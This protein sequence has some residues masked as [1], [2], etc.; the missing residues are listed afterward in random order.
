MGSPKLP[1]PNFS[2]PT[3]Y[4]PSNS[5]PTT[6]S[7]STSNLVNAQTNPENPAAGENKNTRPPA[8]EGG[9]RR[10]LTRA[11]SNL[12]LFSKT[13]ESNPPSPSLHPSEFGAS[14]TDPVKSTTTTGMSSDVPQN[15]GTRPSTLHRMKSLPQLQ[16][17]MPAVRQSSFSS[18]SPASGSPTLLGSTRLRANRDAAIANHEIFQEAVGLAVQEY[19]ASYPKISAAKAEELVWKH[20]GKTYPKMSESEIAAAISSDCETTIRVVTSP[21]LEQ[22][23]GKIS[24]E[25]EKR[26][27][28]IKGEVKKEDFAEQWS[29]HVS[30]HAAALVVRHYPDMSSDVKEIIGK[31]LDGLKNVYAGTPGKVVSSDPS[32]I[33]TTLVQRFSKAK[34]MEVVQQFAK[35][36]EADKKKV[37]QDLID[38][39]ER[40]ISKEAHKL[41]GKIHPEISTLQSSPIIKKQLENHHL[42]DV[43]FI[44][45]YFKQACS[46]EFMGKLI[47][48]IFSACQ[49]EAKIVA[50][51]DLIEA[52]PRLLAQ[53]II[54]Q[55]MKKRYP[56]MSVQEI[57]RD[58][59]LDTYIHGIKVEKIT[60]L[61][62]DLFE[63]EYR[64]VLRNMLKSKVPELEEEHAGAV[65][66]YC[67]KFF[68]G[69]AREK[70]PVSISEKNEANFNKAF[71]ERWTGKYKGMSALENAKALLNEIL[72]HDQSFLPDSDL[73]Q[74]IPRTGISETTF[75]RNTI[76]S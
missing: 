60:A 29:M 61:A 46:E 5:S 39:W 3:S 24:P 33:A 31:M 65:I 1:P 27:Q 45:K 66:D 43:E 30:Q 71:E 32:T 57:A 12:S 67:K 62:E 14:G 13:V 37:V 59:S 17:R 26:S 47:I 2:Y 20:L 9:G 28:Q 75:L 76:K 56:G 55:D 10:V 11:K 64:S 70:S 50:A 38:H 74:L 19:M 72:S 49:K 21:Q 18:L 58:I 25:M 44:G 15:K 51:Q 52:T 73:R 63:T 16:L 54:D 41:M 7:A 22:L 53:A 35:A 68:Y 42:T 6:P 23:V 8:N 36:E 48:D 40:S 4:S 69:K 34:K